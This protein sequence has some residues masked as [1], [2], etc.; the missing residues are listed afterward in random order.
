M[1]RIGHKDAAL[2]DRSDIG[3]EIRA[4]G[5][6]AEVR[7]SRVGRSV[8]QQTFGIASHEQLAPIV[9]SGSGFTETGIHWAEEAGVS[10]IRV[11]PRGDMIPV[12][13]PA[14]LL[15]ERDDATPED[16]SSW[17]WTALRE[18]RS[19]GKPALVL[20]QRRDWPEDRFSVRLGVMECRLCMTPIESAQAVECRFGHSVDEPGL[21]W[22]IGFRVVSS[23]AERLTSEH[24]F[25]CGYTGS[26]HGWRHAGFPH[27]PA[28]LRC[29]RASL[30]SLGWSPK[31]FTFET[32]GAWPAK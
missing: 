22:R 9:F 29:L 4:S 23:P 20:A 13:S 32:D 11:A 16:Q 30:A 12:T 5:A 3:I 27:A 28:A 21:P 24:E 2:A 25:I 10:L 7:A 19:Q 1:R 17:F 8:I 26:H 6:I 18:V 31:E 14:A 15:V